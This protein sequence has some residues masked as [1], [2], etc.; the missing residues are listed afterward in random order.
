MPPAMG[1]GVRSVKCVLSAAE[2]GMQC[3]C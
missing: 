2:S 1:V 3:G